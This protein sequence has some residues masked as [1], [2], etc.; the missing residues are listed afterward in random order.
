[1]AIPVWIIRI[2]EKAARE[3]ALGL[4]ADLQRVR[5]KAQLEHQQVVRDADLLYESAVNDALVKRD[6][7]IHKARDVYD[8]AKKDLLETSPLRV[9]A[10]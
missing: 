7:A 8:R 3:Q 10:K 2:E 6:R 9:V 4:W 1:M 5:E